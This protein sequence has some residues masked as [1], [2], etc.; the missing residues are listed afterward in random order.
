MARY[1]NIHTQMWFDDKF[2]A[3]DDDDKLL[4]IYLLTSPHSNM[5]GYYRLPK[6]YVA[7]D[8]GKGLE[9]VTEGF[10]NL[11]EIGF[12]SY[13]NNSQIVL[14]HNYL[15]YN[16]IQN[17]NQAK[18]AI[19][20]VNELP[21]NNLLS[22]FLQCVE[23][24]SSQ[25]YELLNKG[26]R[27]GLE[28]LSNTGTGTVTGTVTGTGTVTEEHAATAETKNVFKIFEENIHPPS[29]LE[30]EKLKDWLK[31]MDEE[32]I[33][34][35][36]EEAVNNNIRKINYINGILNNWHDNNL[37]TKEDVLAYKR[38][39]A[40]KQKSNDKGN[41]KR[42]DNSKNKLDMDH[43]YDMDKIEEMILKRNRG[44]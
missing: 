24:N 17:N 23:E 19:K 37:M 16:Q 42:N 12:I 40:E 2:T 32:V 35:A 5:A 3:L 25:Y 9:R 41:Y 39:R 38:N 43:D 22:K 33:I 18:G 4:F 44:G 28:T 20:V 29:P 11:I 1:T 36:I 30:I 27:K 8:L 6:R 34:M 15:R 10:Q 7:A 13:D 31:D 21:K 26:L 14:I